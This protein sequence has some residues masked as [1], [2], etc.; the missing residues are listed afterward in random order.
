MQGKTLYN[1]IFNYKGSRKED[2]VRAYSIEQAFRLLCARLSVDLNTTAYAVRQYF[3]QKAQSYEIK[4][5]KEDGK[6][7]G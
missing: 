7:K 2:F 3:S 5:V 6:S 4:E 1:G